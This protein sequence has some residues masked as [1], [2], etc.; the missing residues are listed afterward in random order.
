MGIGWPG[1]GD[2]TASLSTCLR[3]RHAPAADARASAFR[4]RGLRVFLAGF[5]S[6]ALIG[7]L[8][9]KGRVLAPFGPMKSAGAEALTS[10]SLGDS[11]RVE[12]SGGRAPGLRQ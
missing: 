7:Y 12:L 2:R 9:P 11:C 5:W 10:K 8:L 1:V 4:G 3:A 6:S